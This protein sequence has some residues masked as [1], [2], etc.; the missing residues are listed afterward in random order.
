MELSFFHLDSINDSYARFPFILEAQ[1]LEG[2]ECRVSFCSAGNMVNKNGSNGP[3][4]EAFFRALGKDI[5]QVYACTQRHSRTVFAVD[6]NSLN[7][8]P[9][10]D[11]LVTADP[12]ICL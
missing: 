3:E 6:R 11:G 2:L 12:E 4:R 10:G 1:A 8:G 7:N 9:Q 5:R